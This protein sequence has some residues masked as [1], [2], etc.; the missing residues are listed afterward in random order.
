MGQQ[1]IRV[2]VRRDHEE[3]PALEELGE[4]PIGQHAVGDVV[5]RELVDAQHDP[6]ADERVERRLDG[7]AAGGVGAARDIGA[8]L[9]GVHG[10]VE[11]AEELVVVHTPGPVVAHA[12]EERVHQPALAAS[13]LTP[14]IYAASRLGI[15]DRVARGDASTAGDPVEQQLEARRGAELR[16]G[17]AEAGAS[18]VLRDASGCGFHR[19]PP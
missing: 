6:I 1:L 10:P 11:V 8:A 13:D 19:D 16:V 2:V 7:G 17:E 14:Q 3:E 4:E 12:R 15:D 5:D 18:R 9:P